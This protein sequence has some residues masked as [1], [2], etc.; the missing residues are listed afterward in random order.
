MR[1]KNRSGMKKTIGLLCLLCMFVSSLF[2]GC[3]TEAGKD[4][5]EDNKEQA[6][7]EAI[8]NCGERLRE[9]QGTPWERMRS[10]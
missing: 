8:E 2:A 9:C 6:D 1:K 4:K 5:K 3:K 10:S 7:L